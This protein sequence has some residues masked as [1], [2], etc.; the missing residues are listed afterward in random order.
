MLDFTSALYLGMQ[1]QADSMHPWQQLTTGKPA[2]LYSPSRQRCVETV[3]TNL[4]G[5]EQAVLGQSTFHLFWDLFGMLAA[6]NIAIY[7]DRAAYPIACWGAER[8]AARGVPV[9]YFAHH[10]L[11]TLKRQLQESANEQLTP[12]IVIDG[13]CPG[14]ARFAP[15][16]KLIAMIRPYSGLLVIDDT[17]ALGIFG[18]N[19]HRQSPYGMTGG[20]SLNCSAIQSQ[21]IVLI[22]SLAKGFGVPVAMLAGSHQM[23]DFFKSHSQTRVHMSP[24]SCAIVHATEHALRVN[25]KHGKMLRNRLVKLIYLFRQLLDQAG[26]QLTNSLFPLQTLSGLPNKIIFKLF[27]QLKSMGIQALIH[28][29]RCQQQAALSFVITANHQ[30]A[31]IRYTAS[32]LSDLVDHSSAKQTQRYHHAFVNL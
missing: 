11:Q 19:R 15:I 2:A 31:Q 28:Q 30:A 23:I 3:L 22:S 20:G 26:I 9:E 16:S 5:T 27:H 18:E 4:V 17:Q 6:N 14:C 13:Y 24:P 12:V 25:Q 7:L 10:N 1:H 29:L 21:N 32:A 8:A